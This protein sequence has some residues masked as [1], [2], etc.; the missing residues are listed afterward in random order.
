MVGRTTTT[1]AAEAAA[2]RTSGTDNHG[3]HGT[4]EVVLADCFAGAKAEAEAKRVAR[5]AAVFMMM[6]RID[7]D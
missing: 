2:A 4:Y 5:T 3:D 6:M 1:A 7:K